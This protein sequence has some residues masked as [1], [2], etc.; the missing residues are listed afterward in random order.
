MFLKALTIFGLQ[1]LSLQ[2]VSVN[3][4]EGCTAENPMRCADGVCRKECD[5]SVLQVPRFCSEANNN[6]QCVNNTCVSS[7]AECRALSNA[8]F[9]NNTRC[10]TDEGHARCKDGYCRLNCSLLK[11]SNCPL[12]EPFKCG[13]GRCVKFEYECSSY[14][15]PL[16][17]PF[18]CPDMT[19]ARFMKN[20]S[21]TMA[22]RVFKRI[23]IPYNLGSKMSKIGMEIDGNEE[24]KN[25]TTTLL[26]TIRSHFEIFAPPKNSPNLLQLVNSSFNDNCTMIVD[27][28]SWDD[29]DGVVNSIEVN[30]SVS[31]DEDYPFEHTTVRRFFTVR[32]PVLNISTKGRKD[33]NE[34]YAKPISIRFMYN[35]IKASKNNGTI[36]NLQVRFYY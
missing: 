28:I 18:L 15:C 25:G 5:M 1:W 11:Y 26:F 34:Y 32:S 24:L 36:D 17:R 8:T 16:N 33:D 27:P 20:C 29:V 23:E 7:Y 30:R 3:S 6:Y 31:F 9:A 19:C 12:T 2:Q 10:A 4:D 35:P 13:D 21:S 22:F 14:T